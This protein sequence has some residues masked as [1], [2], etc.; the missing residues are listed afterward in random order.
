MCTR[1]Q[2][3]HAAAD[4]VGRT[5]VFTREVSCNWERTGRG[6]K[7]GA[8]KNRAIPFSLCMPFPLSSPDLL[9]PFPLLHLRVSL[10]VSEIPRPCWVF[11]T[12]GARSHYSDRLVPMYDCF[13]FFKHSIAIP[14]LTLEF[15]HISVFLREPEAFRSRCIL[16]CTVMNFQKSLWLQLRKIHLDHPSR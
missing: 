14:E 9:S 13:S 1:V 5:L 10:R 3:G 8:F 16:G 2:C 6:Q 11:S 4:P 12:S 15:Q 7:V